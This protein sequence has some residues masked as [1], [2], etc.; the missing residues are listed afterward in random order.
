MLL[1]GAKGRVI[2]DHGYHSICVLTTA[3]FSKSFLF[4]L[5]LIYEVQ[6]A[7]VEVYVVD[8]VVQPT[9]FRALEKEEYRSLWKEFRE[10]WVQLEKIGATWWK[11]YFGKLLE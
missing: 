8:D 9:A 6:M 5:R 2:I 4:S 10:E 1:E 11:P 7:G 3:T